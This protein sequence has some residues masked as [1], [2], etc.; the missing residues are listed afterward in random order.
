MAG[1][2]DQTGC[3]VTDVVW[4]VALERSGARAEWDW[5]ALGEPDVR[6]L[7]ST[8]RP[9]SGDFSRH[10][11][12]TAYSTTTGS[13]HELESGLEHDL[14]RRLDRDPQVAWLVAQPVLL[15]GVGGRRGSHTPDLLCLRRDGSV[16]VW[17]ARPAQRHDELFD[18]KSRGTWAA[19]AA[20]GWGYD[21]FTGFATPA[22][23]LNELWLAG[24]R[25][26]WPWH[27]ESGAELLARF[28]DDFHI[29]DVYDAS[30][31][32]GHL[33][34]TLWHLLWRGDLVCDLTRPLRASTELTW[35]PSRG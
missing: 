31:E 2:W 10:I 11:P 22:Q 13:H 24:H 16:T 33:V 8:R 28:P 23:R 17:D 34:N 30:D 14:L 1:R 15:F 19:C 26:S 18:R 9:S 25:R 6:H 35:R 32:S 20:V 7:L 4:F 29:R 12:V 3:S 5:A 21:V 27:A